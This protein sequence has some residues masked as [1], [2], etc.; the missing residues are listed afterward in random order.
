MPYRPGAELRPLSAPRVFRTRA[1]R[2]GFEPLDPGPLPA[3]DRAPTPWR[4]GPHTLPIWTGKPVSRLTVDMTAGGLGDAIRT[5][6]VVRGALREGRVERVQIVANPGAALTFLA[7][8]VSPISVVPPRE[9]IPGDAVLPP[10][11]MMPM[12]AWTAWPV[13][14]LTG[15]VAALVGLP[16]ASLAGPCLNVAVAEVDAVLRALQAIG[17]AEEPV[18]AVQTNGHA[19]GAALTRAL[20]HEKV[21][22]GLHDLVPELTRRGFFVMRVGGPSGADRSPRVLDLGGST[23][24]RMA[25][26]LWVADLAVAG[27][28]GPL[29]M[30]AAIG[31]PVVTLFG[32]S[33]PAMHVCAIGTQPVV[34]PASFCPHLPCGAGSP[35]GGPTLPDHSTR[36]PLPCP[37]QGGCLSRLSG[38]DLGRAL[39]VVFQAMRPGPRAQG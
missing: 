39:D 32:P 13:K 4:M 16:I 14:P 3:P 28:S 8:A 2:R 15:I 9:A 21:P 31:T 7:G 37:P 26:A 20:H 18:I 22:H 12:L 29:H 34:P 36:V 33:D 17:W 35:L 38:A 30:A 5:L 11:Y 10:C 1:D 24:A 25:A 6:A 23:L 19:V 27:D